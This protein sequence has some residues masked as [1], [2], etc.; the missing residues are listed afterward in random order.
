[1]NFMIYGE[2]KGLLKFLMIIITI[3]LLLC[4]YYCLPGKEAEQKELESE[5]I[6]V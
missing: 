4:Y 6:A 5:E 3:L 2:K 1:M